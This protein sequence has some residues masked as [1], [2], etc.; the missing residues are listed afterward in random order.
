M[1]TQ[2]ENKQAVPQLKWSGLVA[3]LAAPVAWWFLILYVVSPPLLPYLTTPEGEV[4][5]WA[6]NL[7]QL[8]G[9]LFE[10][11]LAIFILRREGQSMNWQALKERLNLRWGNWKKWLLFL[12]LLVVGF[13]LTMAIS[14][15]TKMTANLLPPP[16][17]FPA[18]QNPL[19]PVNSVEDALPGITL[20]GNYLFLALFLFTGIMNIVGEDTYYRGV[21][22]PKL[23]GLFGRWA[24][25]A[26][27]LM[28]T[29]KHLYV[30]WRIQETLPL[31]L[32]GA[33]IF[34]PMGS[35]PLAML[36]HFIGNFAFSWPMV[37]KM[38]LFG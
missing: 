38:V 27:G 35:L 25:V 30:W 29:L 21:L 11:V 17:W 12:V 33:Y 19:K 1:S 37:I 8:A 5:G 34:G 24:W 32:A 15:T 36:A 6:L 26:G 23:E 9:Y 18:S 4:N 31:A 3:F 28:F 22:I 2:K 20:K 10:F 7:I 16:D 13:G 14:P